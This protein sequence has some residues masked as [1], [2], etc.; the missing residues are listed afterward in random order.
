MTQ[1]RVELWKHVTAYNTPQ[2]KMLLKLNYKPVTGCPNKFH[3]L[4]VKYSWSS[5]TGNKCSASLSMSSP[6]SSLHSDPA[7]LVPHDVLIRPDVVGR[8]SPC[9]V[10]RVTLQ[11]IKI[12]YWSVGRICINCHCQSVSSIVNY[13]KYMFATMYC[14]Y[15]Q[16]CHQD[17][18]PK[19]AVKLALV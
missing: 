18:K 15:H 6:M 19:Q 5:L 9:S 1:S 2:P 8:T 16:L 13:F 4:V 11:Y 14:P 12:Q 17:L 10:P 7:M 3:R